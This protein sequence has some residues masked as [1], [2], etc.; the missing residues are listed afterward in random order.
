M[1]STRAVVAAGATL[2][3]AAVAIVLLIRSS[4]SGPPA[5]PL[6]PGRY[7]RAYASLCEAEV[8]AGNG[9]AAAAHGVFLSRSHTPLHALA[10]QA[11]EVDRAPAARLLE[12]KAAVEVSLP[13]AAPTAGADLR[14]LAEATANAIE[15]ATG[16]RPRSCSDAGK[17]PR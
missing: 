8:L 9:D 13:T 2:V 5:Q 4:T 17:E 16:Q 6:A 14:R 11:A 3:V 1:R 10:A 12:A 7:A 15:T